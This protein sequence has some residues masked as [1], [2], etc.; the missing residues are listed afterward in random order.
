MKHF[1]YYLLSFLGVIFCFSVHSQTTEAGKIWNLEACFQYATEHNIDIN[2][3]KF[4]EQS[5]IQDLS[6]AKGSKI[7][8][9]SA[10]AN[11]IFNNV[12]NNV[13]GNGDYVNQLSTSGTYTVNSSVVLWNG[14]YINN[15]IRQKELLAQTANLSVAQSTN[16]ITLLI[17]QSYLA[18]LLAKENLKYDIDLVATSTEKVKQG[19]KLYDAGSIP[20]TNLLQLQAQLSGDNYLQVQ[21]ENAI[22]QSILTLKQI[23]QLPS[24]T[25]FDIITPVS[26]EIENGI[27]PL[28]NVQQTA[29]ENFPEIKI[30]QLGLD[31]ATLNIEKAKAGFKPTLTA[32]AALGS[33]YTDILNNSRDSNPSYFTQTSNNFYQRIGVTISIPIFSNRINKTNLEKA[34]IGFKQANLS[35]QNNQLVLSQEVEQAYLNT[36]N[37]KQAYAAAKEQLLAVTETYRIG[38]E[39]FKLGGI[40]S[41]D[42]LQLR[43]QY[44]QAVQ[45]FTQSKYTAILQQK[46][47]EF[48]NGSKITL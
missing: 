24:E 14:N 28:K 21:T 18:I 32:N 10:T 25:A 30:G 38:N 29:S 1:Q 11:N 13:S 35:L 23:L 39:Q 43:N 42:L 20:K 16:N 7:P 36:A 17:T 33:N 3:L 40:N 44:V 4:N 27:I 34:N 48:Y 45:S 26:L 2:T 31:I 5:S 9:V 12:K 41:F 46:I 6:A 19:Q 37:A 15:N 47:Y 8:N 22:R